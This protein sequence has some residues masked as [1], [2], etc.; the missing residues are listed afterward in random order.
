[1]IQLMTLR[2]IVLASF[3][4]L[5]AA[6]EA[7]P[8]SAQV[9]PTEF[10]D[11]VVVSGIDQPCALEFTPDGRAL[12][13][14]QRDAQILVIFH[15]SPLAPPVLTVPNVS[16]SGELGLLGVALDPWFPAKPYLYTHQ[17]LNGQQ[18][19]LT[20]WTLTGDLTGTGSGN[21][22][23][24]PAS[25]FDLITDI[26]NQN[27]IHNGGTVRFGPD[28][29]LYVSLG[30]DSDPC[31]AQDPTL[32]KGVILRLDVRTLPA[33]AGA[34]TRAQLTPSDNPFVTSPDTNKRLV[35]AYGL[36]NPFRF[37]I[38]PVRRWLVIGDVGQDTYEEM[39]L[40]AMP[41]ATNGAA[42]AG[43]NF[44]W[45]WHE[46]LATYT[47]CAGAE[48]PS[49]APIFVLDRSSFAGAAI[50]SA[51]AYQPPA[52]GTANWPASYQGDVFF[53]DYYSG[54]LWR[55]KHGATWDIA[56]AVQG[57]PDPTHWAT[58]IAH[59]S[60]FRIAADGSLWYV[61][62]WSGSF[63][64]T[65]SVHRIGYVASASV[66]PPPVSGLAVRL[67]ARP[68]PAHVPV[69]LS[70]K[71][72]APMVTSLHVYDMR[73][74]HVRTLLPAREQAAAAYDVP[75]DGASDDGSAMPSGIYWARLE[76]GTE[77]T[78]VKLPLLR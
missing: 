58:N 63:A 68:L 37:Q 74:R 65:G 25:E 69:V 4:A 49:V 18:L 39:D 31:G 34:A 19:T 43:S 77:H 26:P 46:G 78:S 61:S 50:V 62:Q 15:G 56:P 75:W 24:D 29:M 48:P 7:S 64:G 8:A 35:Y 22:V 17:T 13:T 12:I 57:Q 30:E 53:A 44:G 47:V 59:A 6:S 16:T 11:S 1:M 67:S 32:L 28:S 27:A 40:L 72:S 73:G 21:M 5:L 55:L 66:Q 20:R 42:P 10:S 9:L 23:A 41:G 2:S 71:L 54:G 51:G 70:Y 60:D 52:T 38:D 14:T 33:G 45:P 36:R 3:L 76:A